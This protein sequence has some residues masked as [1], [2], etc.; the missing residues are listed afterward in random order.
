M[1]ARK[2]KVSNYYWTLE[3]KECED[4]ILVSMYGN[5]ITSV[6]V[7]NEDGMDILRH[8]SSRDLLN[9]KKQLNKD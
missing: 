1:E 3:G 7:N 8:L 6:Q 5:V 9:I 4:D 2:C